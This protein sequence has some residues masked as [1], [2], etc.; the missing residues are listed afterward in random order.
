M[1]VP[2]IGLTKLTLP[3]VEVLRAMSSALR[4]KCEY[5]MHHV[6]PARLEPAVYARNQGA[7]L[8]KLTMRLVAGA[9]LVMTY[10][11]EGRRPVVLETDAIPGMTAVLC[12]A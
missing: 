8:S 9:F 11:F 2:V 1:P 3:I 4:Q 5:P 6:I 7:Q 12:T 10:Y